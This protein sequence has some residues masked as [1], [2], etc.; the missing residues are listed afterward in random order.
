[1]VQYTSGV[2]AGAVGENWLSTDAAYGRLRQ[3]GANVLAHGF[4][5]KEDRPF[6]GWDGFI[7]VLERMQ[8]E[9]PNTKV[10]AYIGS[11]S[12]ATTENFVWDSGEGEYI[13][14]ERWA[15]EVAT[16]SLTY[17]NLIGIALDD[18][19]S[20]AQL[21]DNI[22]GKVFTPSYMD[23]VKAA[24][25]AINSE[26]KI[27]AVVYIQ[28]LSANITKRFENSLDTIHYFYRH[29]PS[30]DAVD[31]NPERIRDEITMASRCCRNDVVSQLASIQRISTLSAAIGNFA[32]VEATINL[33]DVVGDLVVCYFENTKINV[34]DQGYVVKKISFGGDLLVDEDIAISDTAGELEVKKVTIPASTIADLLVEGP[35]AVL[36]LKL[37]VIQAYSSWS[38]TA[39]IYVQQSDL[40][41][42]WT[43][44]DATSKHI[45]GFSDSLTASKEIN[46]SVYGRDAS[47]FGVDATYT[48]I[49]LP[50]CQERYVAGEVDGI[51]IWEAVLPT[52]GDVYE[53]YVQFSQS[54]T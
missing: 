27:A 6:P 21:D 49:I 31:I 24:G 28:G 50:I 44:T 9:A 22:T 20:D 33:E 48:G 47:F 30:E 5:T 32:S 40:A 11:P 43:S 41:V 16:L 12:Y 4:W 8:R 15:E 54:L 46:I 52:D 38:Y 36:E 34:P 13:D 3:L 29:F 42:S 18:F 25:V 51:S 37:E 10:L 39:N 35:T 2:G 19:N 53:L 14:Y 26:F 17:T 1:M 45:I 23:S 7:E